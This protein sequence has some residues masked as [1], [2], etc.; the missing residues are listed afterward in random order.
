MI[1]WRTMDPELELDEIYET[2]EDTILLLRV[3]LQEARPDDRVLEIGC[4][5]ALISRELAMRVK[6]I[7]AT[8]IN[9]V[10]LRF[11]R[12]VGLPAVRADLFS[13]FKARFDLIIFNPP[14]LPTAPEER[15]K[16]WINFSLDGGENGRE[17]IFRFLEQIK[18]YLSPKGR[19]LF[20]VSSFSGIAEVLDKARNEGLDI[21]EIASARYFFEQLCVFKVEIAISGVKRQ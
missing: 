6:S 12:N 20:L 9:P 13:G 2:A 8:D 18:N 14:Y 21:S 5:R 4:G 17:T 15:S 10:A 3:A 7:V 1:T 11:A 16:G 19:S